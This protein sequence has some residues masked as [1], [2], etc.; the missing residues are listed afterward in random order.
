MPDRGFRQCPSCQQFVWIEGEGD[1]PEHE[2][3]RPGASEPSRCDSGRLPPAEWEQRTGIV[4]SSR[5]GWSG[6]YADK[7]WDTPISRHEF[8]RRAMASETAP[9]PNPLLDER[10]PVWSR[11]R[12]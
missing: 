8:L 4:I 7:T 5:T 11:A 10:R 12:G 1:L 6:A 9:W 3:W 2:V